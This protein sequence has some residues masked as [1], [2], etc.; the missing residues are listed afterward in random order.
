M[1]V[2]LFYIWIEEMKILY[3]FILCV[4]VKSKIDFGEFFFVFEGVYMKEIKFES[5]YNLR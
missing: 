4:D 3:K 2:F 5:V 1:S